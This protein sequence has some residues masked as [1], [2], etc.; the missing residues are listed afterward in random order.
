[1]RAATTAH[2]MCTCRGHIHGLD[3]CVGPN[4]QYARP[5]GT[6]FYGECR[7]LGGVPAKV[8]AACQIHRTA[9]S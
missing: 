4:I 8:R 6:T 3:E 5:D 9:A 7:I 1:M 2:P